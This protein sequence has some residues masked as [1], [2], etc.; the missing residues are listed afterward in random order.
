MQNTHIAYAIKE[1]CKKNKVAIAK[2]LNECNVNRNFIY[3]LEKKS[4]SPSCDKISRIAD[5]LNCSVDYL[6]GR[7]YQ[8]SVNKGSNAFIQTDITFEQKRLMSLFE[9]ISDDDKQK[10]IEYAEMLYEH[11]EMKKDKI[12]ELLKDDATLINI[13]KKRGGH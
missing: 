5:R 7:T 13:K 11:S 6:L 9:K 8:V 12:M 1:Q 2:V 3:D 4:T 10:L